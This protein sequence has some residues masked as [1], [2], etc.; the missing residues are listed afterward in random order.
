MQFSA[1]FLASVLAFATALPRPQDSTSGPVSFTL[2]PNFNTVTQINQLSY[3]PF[4][5]K[6]GQPLAVTADGSSPVTVTQG[7]KVVVTA[8]LGGNPVASQTIDMC[9]EGAKVGMPC[10]VTA[11]VHKFTNVMP[12]PDNVPPFVD[13]AVHAEAFNGDGSPLFCVDTTANFQP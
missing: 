2:C 7:A 8:S 11:G 10:P 3:S 13:I 9:A 6:V 5:P 4:P 1:V 12:L